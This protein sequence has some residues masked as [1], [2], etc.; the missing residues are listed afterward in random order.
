MYD[1]GS[2]EFDKKNSDLTHAGDNISYSALESRISITMNIVSGH[3]SK[4]TYA[5]SC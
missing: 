5:V 3:V 2:T 1:T 4:N